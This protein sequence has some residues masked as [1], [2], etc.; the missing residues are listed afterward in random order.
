ML[1]RRE[2]SVPATRPGAA[3]A[4]KGRGLANRAEDS[5][6]GGEWR[7]LPAAPKEEIGGPQT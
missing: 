6:I 2:N 1:R 4:K 3:G 7:N 5:T